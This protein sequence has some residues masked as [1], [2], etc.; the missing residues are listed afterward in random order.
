[1]DS[2][3]TA[4]GRALRGYAR[5]RLSRVQG[6][7][8]PP[9]L[10]PARPYRAKL[11]LTY[12]CNLR[13]G[14]CYTDSPR[15]TLER[16]PELDDGVWDRI[17]EQSI[18]LGIGEAGI[19]G[20]EPLLRRDVAVDAIERLDG[21][22]LDRVSLTTNGWFIDEA[23]AD[24]LAQARTLQV[25]ISIDGPTPELHDAA[26]GV[27]GSWRR[28]VRAADLL[29]SRGVRVQVLH[30]I[31][32]HNERALPEFLDT[33]ALLG[34]PSLSLT[35]VVPVGA[36][37]RS[38]RWAV[39]RLRIY[40]QVRAFTV[41]TGGNPR[42]TLENGFAG[43]LSTPTY[44]PNS[45]MV[46]PDG[47]FLA[48]SNHPFSFGNAATQPLAECWEALRQGWHDERVRRW[49]QGMPRNRRI[50]D[51]DLVP[52]RDDELEVFGD[53]NGK[54]RAPAASRGSRT[55]EEA[56]E[57]LASKSP[58]PPA[59]GIGDLTAATAHV[60]ELAAARSLL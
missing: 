55:V 50:P 56:L 34:V 35:P 16:T 54:K 6:R 58:V 41:K 60:R 26:R 19:I 10:P 3:V 23:L 38:G 57:I 45:F 39:N 15:R 28:A 4:A 7:G 9:A 48:D 11:E 12:H 40:R 8:R 13:C 2:T 20:G 17:V 47:A 51:M 1:M 59:D 33:M 44:T 5:G 46:R 42:I 43:R 52:Y 32:P 21:A 53:G 27:P 25:Y 31:T 36:A 49:I 29:L 37:A 22:E 14:F 30:V 18:E 24:R